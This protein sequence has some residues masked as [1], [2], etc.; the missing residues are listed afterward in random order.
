[1]IVLIAAGCSND[2][3]RRAAW[4]LPQNGEGALRRASAEARRPSPAPAPDRVSEPDRRRPSRTR[5]R[6]L[7]VGELTAARPRVRWI[8]G[9]PIQ[10]ECSEVRFEFGIAASV[11]RL[12][13]R[14][15][16][17]STQSRRRRIIERPRLI[18]MLDGSQGR[19]RMLVAPAGLRQDDA[20]PPVARGQEGRLVHGFSCVDRCRRACC[21]AIGSGVASSSRNWSRAD[22]TFVRDHRPPEEV[23]TLEAMLARDLSGWPRDNWLVQRRLPRSLALGRRRVVDR[24]PTQGRRLNALI[25]SRQRPRWASSRRM[26]YGEIFEVDRNALAMRDEEA[27]DMLGEAH[28]S[29]DVIGATPWLASRHPL[30]SLQSPRRF[31]AVPRAEPQLYG[32]FADEIFAPFGSTDT[33]GQLCE[34]ALYD[35]AG[36]RTR[37]SPSWGET[38]RSA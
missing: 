38:R 7:R 33:K 29:A 12:W 11:T 16:Q 10:S 9:A 5:P 30:C 2:E 21:R 8:A 4:H 37:R 1:M 35:R 18:R 14:A 19:I 36:R 15:P 3:V 26:L 34:L 17:P 13:A 31:R 23:R 27:A 25:V 24:T 22:G 20:R 28:A 6:P 32:F